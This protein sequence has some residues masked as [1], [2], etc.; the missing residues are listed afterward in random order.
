MITTYDFPTKIVF[1]PGSISMLGTEAAKLGKR[2]MLVTGTTSTRGT[3]LLDRVNRDLEKNGL[4]V[5]VFDKVVP[6]PRASTIDEGARLAHQDAVDLVIGLGGGSAMDSAKGI[7]LASASKKPIW[8]YVKEYGVQPV[9]DYPE[10]VPPILLAPTMA[11]SGSESGTACVLAND[12][13]HQKGLIF[14]PAFYPKLSIVDP[15]LTLTLSK[16]Q[17]V[18]GGAD[19]F[20]HVVEPYITVNTPCALTD[21]IMETLMKLVVNS[22]PQAIAKPDDIEARIA[23]SWASTLAGSPVKELGGGVGSVTLH[24]IERPLEGYND[25]THGDGLAAMLPAWMKYTL[26]VRRERFASLG[27]NVFGEADGITAVE[28][29]LDKIGMRLKLRDLGIKPEDF[30]S[31]AKITL[32]SDPR[33]IKHPNLLNESVIMQLYEDSY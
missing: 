8:D 30:Q 16:E 18:T 10:S 9:E 20:C 28:K 3:G 27:K 21:G 31:L 7:A 12:E 15:E 19:I 26:P 32:K 1:G 11:A 5:V 14:S 17:T 4:E 25:C 33:I 22:L 6:N 23:L 29:W 13:T 24:S 2:A